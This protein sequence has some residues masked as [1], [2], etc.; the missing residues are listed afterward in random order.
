VRSGRIPR[1]VKTNINLRPR[2]SGRRRLPAPLS[3]K[4]HAGGS[5]GARGSLRGRCLEPRGLRVRSSGNV[6]ASRV[7]SLMSSRLLG[8]IPLQIAPSPIESSRKRYKTN[9]RC[10]R[11]RTTGAPERSRRHVALRNECEPL[12]SLTNGAIAEPTVTCVG[13]SVF[14]GAWVDRSMDRNRLIYKDSC[15]NAV[16]LLQLPRMA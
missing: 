7:A 3:C 1:R 9:F 6:R 11:L 13:H 10:S 15:P 4:L 14:C 2:Y 12:H 5:A 8:R 16:F